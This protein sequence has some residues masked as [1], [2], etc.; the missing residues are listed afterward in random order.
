MDGKLVTDPTAKAETLK[1]QLQSVFSKGQEYTNN[2]FSD[3]SKMNSNTPEKTLSDIKVNKMGIKKLLKKLNSHKAVV[4]YSK[5]FN[6]FP[7]AIG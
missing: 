1:K 6:G 3:E 4:V 5:T 7:L 2:E